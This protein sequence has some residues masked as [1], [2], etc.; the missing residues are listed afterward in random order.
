MLAQG[1]KHQASILAP[2]KIAVCLLEH[3]APNTVSSIQC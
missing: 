1:L 2:D 3:G